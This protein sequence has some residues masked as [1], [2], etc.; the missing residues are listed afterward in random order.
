[1]YKYS[2]LCRGKYTVN[3]LLTNPN[4]KRWSTPNLEVEEKVLV[5]ATP[6]LGVLAE[7]LRELLNGSE[8]LHGEA[9]RGNLLK[10]SSDGG[11]TLREK[12]HL[13]IGRTVV[14]HGEE[15]LQE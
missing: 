9:G 2:P 14:Q 12:E 5:D 11:R 8:C 10:K 6:L 15:E 13:L 3:E 4:C 7:L 1:M